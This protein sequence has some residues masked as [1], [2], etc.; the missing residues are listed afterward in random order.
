I[1]D[2]SESETD[3]KKI[4]SRI[5]YGDRVFIK[6][7][8]EGAEHRALSGL[9]DFQER[10]TGLVI[11]FH[12]MIFLRDSV[13][14]IIS[15]IKEFFDIVHVHVNNHK[16]VDE[17]GMPDVIEVTF[18][19]KNLRRGDDAESGRRYPVEGLDSPNYVVYADFRLV[20]EP[21]PANSRIRTSSSWLGSS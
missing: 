16:G 20:F 2:G 19:N 5:P 14:K 10:I 3:F 9:G 4:F 1:G 11:E 15:G 7:D 18:E 12:H 21:E 6:I 8:I 13:L 17:G